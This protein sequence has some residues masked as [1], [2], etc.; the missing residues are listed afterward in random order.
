MT[1]HYLFFCNVLKLI[2]CFYQSA[3][4]EVVIFHDCIVFISL[5]KLVYLTIYALLDIGPLPSFHCQLFTENFY[6]FLFVC[7]YVYFYRVDNEKWYHQGSRI[8]VLL[9]SLYCQITFHNSV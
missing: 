8:F 6:I 5:D 2:T 7:A 4:I 3:H 9:F 1:S